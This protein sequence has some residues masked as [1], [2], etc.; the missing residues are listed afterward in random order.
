MYSRAEACICVIPL[1]MQVPMVPKK[2]PQHGNEVALGIGV[3][4][5]NLH[6]LWE[7]HANQH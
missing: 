6:Q 5:Q 4:I 3:K 2:M 7:Q 1:H